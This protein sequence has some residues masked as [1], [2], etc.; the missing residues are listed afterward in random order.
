MMKLNIRSILIAIIA[1]TIG[2]RTVDAQTLLGPFAG[3]NSCRNTDRGDRILGPMYGMRFQFRG[4][5]RN[6]A[7]RPGVAFVRRG[8]IRN[9][10]SQ[11]T[12]YQ[13]EIHIQC[14]DVSA[15]YTGWIGRGNKVRPLL[16]VAPSISFPIGE[17]FIERYDVNGQDS[18]VVYASNG[19]GPPAIGL[20]LGSGLTIT[21]KKNELT[22]E[23]GYQF[24]FAQLNNEIGSILHYDLY[25]LTVSYL[26]DLRPES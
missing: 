21:D 17:V 23:F 1:F 12:G 2:T 9:F 14:V 6:D 11:L 20:Y 7:F 8:Y 15:L 25:F 22:F 18:T 13:H 16:E 3:A 24:N 19:G 26:F 4:E 10:T 5:D